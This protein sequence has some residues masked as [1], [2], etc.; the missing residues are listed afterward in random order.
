MAKGELSPEEIERLSLA[1]R[2]LETWDE[3]NVGVEADQQLRL[4]DA[5]ITELQPLADHPG[6]ASDLVLRYQALA[7]DIRQRARSM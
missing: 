6:R 1:E 5:E 7:L 2:G 4:I 3:A